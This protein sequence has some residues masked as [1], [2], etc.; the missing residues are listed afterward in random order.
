[1]VSKW[2]DGRVAHFHDVALG[3]G[4][5]RGCWILAVLA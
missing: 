5:E 2:L 4:E 3:R 1:M